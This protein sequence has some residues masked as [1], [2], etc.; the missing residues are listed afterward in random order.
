MWVLACVA[1]RLDGSNCPIKGRDWEV[2][3][4]K[5]GI[6][7]FAGFRVREVRGCSKKGGRAFSVRSGIG[8]DPVPV[9]SMHARDRCGVIQFQKV[10]RRGCRAGSLV[11]AICGSISVR[12]CA[13]T[14]FTHSARLIPPRKSSMRLLRLAHNI[15]GG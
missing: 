2:V 9:A 11:P 1:G 15:E 8:K 6:Q 7:R 5:T 3:L 12:S 13:D 4:S 10:V 14:S